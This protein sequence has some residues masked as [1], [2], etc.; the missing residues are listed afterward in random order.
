MHI[1]IAFGNNNPLDTSSPVKILAGDIG[2]TKTNLALFDFSSGKYSIL[3]ETRFKTK[4]F[5]DLG[6]M[7]ASFLSADEKPAVMSFGIA[8]PVTENRVKLTN[9]SWGIDGVELSKQYNSTPVYLINDLEAT[10]YGLAVLTPAEL[11]SFYNSGKEA[12]GN[13]ALIAPGTGLGEAGVY[14]DGVT[15]HPFATEGGHSDFA[16]RTLLDHELYLHLNKQ[17]GRVSWERVIS[18]N[19]IVSIFD[20]LADEKCRN[21][22]GELKEVLTLGDKPKVITDNI[23][24]YSICRETIDLFLRYLATEA[25]NLALKMKATGGVF[26][27]GGI[28][29]Q[30]LEHVDKDQFMIYFRDF[31]R[32]SELLSGISV[33]VILNDKTALLGAAYYGVGRAE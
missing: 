21:V 6:E 9:V 33:S 17:F 31:D 20:F 1:P 15:Y 3:K 2:G 28:I 5:N 8:G 18:G 4:D 25:G 23:N 7:I 11:F 24:N 22:P 14:D 26:I 12:R 19:G 32:M 29:P 30:I 27:G 13:L 16:P 10:A